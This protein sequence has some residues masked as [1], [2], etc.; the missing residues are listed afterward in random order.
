MLIDCTTIH[1]LHTLC[2]Y[3][4]PTRLRFRGLA[5]GSGCTGYAK[6][7][8][9][10]GEP[11]ADNTVSLILSVCR[12][13]ALSIIHQYTHS[14]SFFLTLPTS[15]TTP[16]RHTTP[17]SLPP[18][19]TLPTHHY[20][21]SPHYPHVTTPPRHTRH[22]HRSSLTDLHSLIFTGSSNYHQLS[23][24][25][26]H[27]RVMFK[28]Y[29]SQGI[30][31]TPTV[32][33]NGVRVDALTAGVGEASLWSTAQL[34]ALIE[35]LVSSLELALGEADEEQDA[36]PLLDDQEQ[37]QE[38][39]VWEGRERE[40][41]E[42]EGSGGSSILLHAFAAIGAI[43]TAGAVGV[44]AVA[45]ARRFSQR[46]GPR[47]AGSS[48]SGSTSS[49]TSSS[50][51]SSSSG[52]GSSGGGSGGG[53]TP[54]PLSLGG[55]INSGSGS[56]SCSSTGTGIRVA[57]A[58]PLAIVSSGVAKLGRGRGRE[59]QRPLLSS[60]FTSSSPLAIPMRQHV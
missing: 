56:S 36:S 59:E 60:S 38:G 20:L 34:A 6:A 28:Y 3:I 29:A 42:R 50:S 52:G 41:R 21:H 8:V 16:P 44:F 31:S 33:L 23:V 2:R 45:G 51:T 35:P 57:W 17:T 58:N 11:R 26:P 53:L 15:H 18:L 13:V 7:R 12:I 54:S 43:A 25:A 4:D 47:S 10:T 1:S 55:G 46:G 27:D 40:G 39:G 9:G 14:R 37:P 5:V 48:T 32:L 22:T 24:T 30:T 49:S 19:A